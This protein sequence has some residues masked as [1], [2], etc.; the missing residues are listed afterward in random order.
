MFQY[1]VKYTE[2]DIQNNDLFYKNIKNTK[3]NS[4][5]WIISKIENFQFLCRIMYKLYNSYF[6]FG[7]TCKF[8]NFV[9]WDLYTYIYILHV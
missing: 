7:E 6:V 2:S 9:F 3:I 1:R 5:L 8:C 4:N